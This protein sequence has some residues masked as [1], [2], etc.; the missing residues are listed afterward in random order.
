MKFSGLF[1][2]RWIRHI[3][4][5][6][7]V[8]VV[9][10]MT[11]DHLNLKLYIFSWH[12]AS[13]KI[14]IQ[15]GGRVN[16][17]KS[18]SKI[19]D[20]TAKTRSLNDQNTFCCDKFALLWHTSGPYY[21]NSSYCFIELLFLENFKLSQLFLLVFLITNYLFMI[22]DWTFFLNF[23]WTHWLNYGFYVSAC[24]P[25]TNRNV[26]CLDSSQFETVA[27]A[28]WSCGHYQGDNNTWIQTFTW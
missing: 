4:I 14:W 18:C 12:T 2:K 15:K 27:K 10:L 21:L 9:N 8:H 28:T 23:S 7:L 26:R 22:T 20:Q 6:S 16:L 5:T 11:M 17:I 1:L 19:L 3:I 24:V 25:A 13:F